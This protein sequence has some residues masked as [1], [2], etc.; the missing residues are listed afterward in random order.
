MQLILF[1]LEAG[2]RQLLARAET[3]FD[4]G[5]D[6]DFHHLRT[7]CGHGYR[8]PQR[9]SNRMMLAD[10]DIQDPAVDQVVFTIVGQHADEFLGLTVAIDAPLALLVAG[11]LLR[12]AGGEALHRAIEQP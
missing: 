4:D 6:D 9:L 8:D 10:Q 3:G 1:F 2:Q 5:I 12:P 11:C 7:V